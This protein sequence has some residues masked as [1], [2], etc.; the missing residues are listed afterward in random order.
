MRNSK[1]LKSP[2]PFSD[3]S[4]TDKL[5]KLEVGET[6]TDS[7]RL[8]PD[9]CDPDG[10]EKCLKKLNNRW[11]SVILR[12]KKRLFVDFITTTGKMWSASNE[13]YVVIIITRMS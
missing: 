2:R 3:D 12:V 8:E 10:V 7:M 1:I 4:A 6:L 9:D 5:S 13:P 11:S